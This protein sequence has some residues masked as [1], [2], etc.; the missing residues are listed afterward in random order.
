LHCSGNGWRAAIG[1]FKGV[2][3]LVRLQ[4]DCQGDCAVVKSG[5]QQ[6]AV[7]KQNKGLNDII[8]RLICL[9]RAFCSEHW[10]ERLAHENL[11]DIKT[12]K[13]SLSLTIGFD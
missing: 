12:A 4:S 6:S 8:V 11:S 3:Q 7:G 9:A 1:R 5:S 13:Q 2:G 10:L